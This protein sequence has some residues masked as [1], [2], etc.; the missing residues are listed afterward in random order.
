MTIRTLIA[1]SRYVQ[2]KGAIA[3]LGPSLALVGSRPLLVAD[4]LVWGLLKDAASASMTGAGLPLLR[5]TFTGFT[6]KT[7]KCTKSKEIAREGAKKFGMQAQ[8]GTALITRGI[9]VAERFT[10]SLF[11]V[12][13]VSSW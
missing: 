11:F 3:Q 6:T 4:D 8:F 7:A 13:F 5:E 10:A 1:P 9:M 12:H 2:G